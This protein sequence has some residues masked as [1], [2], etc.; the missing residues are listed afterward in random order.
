MNLEWDNMSLFNFP[1][2]SVGHD[3]VMMASSHV[4]DSDRGNDPKTPRVCNKLVNVEKVV[5][6]MEASLCSM[7]RSIIP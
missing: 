1:R 3:V 6:K 5:E 2:T 7:V 4:E